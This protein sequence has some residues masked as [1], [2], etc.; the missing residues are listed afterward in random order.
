VLLSVTR[1]V[2]HVDEALKGAKAK[3]RQRDHGGTAP[4]KQ[5][6]KVSLSDDGRSCDKAARGTGRSGRT[7]EIAAAIETAEAAPE[8]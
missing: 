3:E 2:L 1:A 8:I 6:G 4:G 7:M 5:S